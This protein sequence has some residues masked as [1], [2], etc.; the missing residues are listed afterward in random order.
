MA[1]GD[2]V[3]P[4]E[5]WR[6]LKFEKLNREWDYVFRRLF[7]TWS[8]DIRS[9]S[10]QTPIEIDTVERTG[11]LIRNLDLYVDKAGRAH[12]LYLKQPHQYTFLRDK[13][14]PD[15]P[16]TLQLEYVVLKDGKVLS[17]STLAQGPSESGLSPSFGRF[18]VDGAGRLYVIAAGTRNGKFGNFI[19]RIR[20]AQE[21]P[22]FNRLDLKHPFGNFFTNTPRGGSEPSDVIDVFGIADDN[23]NLRYARIRIGAGNN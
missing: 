9:G 12:V 20:S 19:G 6:K 8:D 17:R 22:E 11:G 13:Y 3:E 7:Y 5:Q 10:F 15:D 4:V 1:I 23:P 14:F 21:E 18:H 2:I 16:M